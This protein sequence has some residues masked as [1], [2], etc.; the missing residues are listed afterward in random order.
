MRFDLDTTTLSGVT[1]TSQIIKLSDV[2]AGTHVI[3]EDVWMEVSTAFTSGTTFG[4]GDGL[5]DN[6][7]LRA[8]DVASTGL[9]SGQTTK[10]VLLTNNSTAVIT[11]KLTLRV[12]STTALSQQ[13]AGS[14]SLYVAFKEI[15]SDCQ[16]SD[17]ASTSSESALGD[18]TIPTFGGGGLQLAGTSGQIQYNDG[19]GQLAAYSATAARTQLGLE[20]ATADSSSAG[21]KVLKVS[22]GG[23]TSGSLLSI[24]SSGEI[25]AGSSVSVAGSSGDVQTN[26]GSGGLGSI[27]I[28][29]SPSAAA[30]GKLVKVSSSGVA[31]G[32]L[33]SLDSSGEI[34][35]G[36][37][38]LENTAVAA[39]SY[40][41]GNVTFDAKG[42]ATGAKSNTHAAFK[43][44][45]PLAAY[46][47][48][49]YDATNASTV[50]PTLGATGIASNLLD[51]SRS[52][53]F[54]THYQY[55]MPPMPVTGNSASG[56]ANTDHCKSFVTY[57]DPNDYDVGVTVTIS[58]AISP[59]YAQ[60]NATDTTYS[61]NTSIVSRQLVLTPSATGFVG[62]P[63]ID[64]YPVYVTTN[65]KFTNTGEDVS[66]NADSSNPGYGKLL[67][68]YGTSSSP[69]VYVF[70]LLPGD[71]VTL[72]V[73]E[74]QNATSSYLYPNGN[75]FYDEQEVDETTKKAWKIV[76]SNVLFSQTELRTLLGSNI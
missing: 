35:A 69:A 64:H 61:S 58:N 23:V 4:V 11:S 59:T 52:N 62:A 76:S 72:S 73:T 33:L 20:V 22:S 44:P 8:T 30:G 10:G 6:S 29:T 17:I 32:S 5:H 60:A 71:S 24:D 37:V 26:N 40:A 3:V 31:S 65:A 42:R 16:A 41:F 56:L 39:G 57:P 55:V 51:S 13:S 21:G 7:F 14:A 50:S 25:V 46:Y 53:P 68:N 66:G 27:A 54:Y 9:K 2:A 70:I 48:L 28:A 34:V 63:A 38:S 74:V 1:N 45:A 36:T 47:P 12:S 43:V 18:G 67:A 75:S 49:S 15:F 19:N